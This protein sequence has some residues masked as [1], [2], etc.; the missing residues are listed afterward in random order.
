MSTE[1]HELCRCELGTHLK[2][3][4]E[5]GGLMRMSC[6][7]C[8]DEIDVSDLEDHL[9]LF[10]PDQEYDLETWP[11][12]GLVWFDDPDGEFEEECMYAVYDGGKSRKPPAGMTRWQVL[13]E[14]HSNDDDPR[15]L[16]R[17]GNWCLE[18]ELN[19]TDWML[20]LSAF[21]EY[22]MG[23]GWDHYVEARASFGPW[24]LTLRCTWKP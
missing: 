5:A 16:W 24:S 1:E 9:R 19:L 23:D 6:L 21:R 11:D 18:S 12:G 15:V 14:K 13:D 3:D 22:G 10:H 2:S 17:R 20:G 8:T 4:H 7:L